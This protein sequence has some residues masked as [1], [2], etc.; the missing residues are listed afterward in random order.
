MNWGPDSE[1]NSGPQLLSEGMAAT[2]GIGPRGARRPGGR[3][4]SV[5]V[6]KIPAVLS[7]MQGSSMALK[8]AFERKGQP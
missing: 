7:M 8:S 1:G 4:E 5:I 6:T 2:S 3:P